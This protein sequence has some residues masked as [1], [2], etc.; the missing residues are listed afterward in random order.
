M[1]GVISKVMSTTEFYCLVKIIDI[2]KTQQRSQNRSLSV[3][4]HYLCDD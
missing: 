4:P 2:N 1:I 3:G